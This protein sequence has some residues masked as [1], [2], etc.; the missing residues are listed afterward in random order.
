MTD[1]SPDEG[2]LMTYPHGPAN[3]RLLAIIIAILV[4]GALGALAL[5]VA[6]AIA[7]ESE[8]SAVA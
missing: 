7:A 8:T 5:G 4:I 3:W 6:G 2:F 1:E